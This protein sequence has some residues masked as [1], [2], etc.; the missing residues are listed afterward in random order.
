MVSLSPVSRKR[1]TRALLQRLGIYYRVKTSFLYDIYWRCADRAIIERRNKEV[2]FYR[3]VLRDVRRGDLAFDVGANAGEKTDVFLRVGLNVLAIEPDAANAAI[4]RAKYQKW[5]MFRM[6]VTI[7]PKAVSNA[8]GLE[9]MYVDAPGSALNTLNPKWAE[10]L[11]AEPER[12]AIRSNFGSHCIVE[13]TTLDDLVERY[14]QPYFIKI[15][16]EG[17][18]VRVLQGLKR[19]APHVSFEVNLPE[20]RAEGQECIRLLERLHPGGIF[21]YAVSVEKGMELETYVTADKMA[22]ILRRRP[23]GSLEVFWKSGILR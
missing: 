11:A 7:I 5:R 22:E 17:H 14:G 13:T 2:Q 8:V 18:E 9:T 12:C 19:P 3:K 6:P 16:V 20:F 10:A 4:L 1:R 21:N 23:G 15:D